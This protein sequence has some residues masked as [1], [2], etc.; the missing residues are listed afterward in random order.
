MRKPRRRVY[1][2]LP[3]KGLR[4]RL[5]RSQQTD[6]SLVHLVNLDLIAT[7]QAD[8]TVMWHLAEDAMLWSRIAEMTGHF[9]AEMQE[10]L[11]VAASVVRRFGVTGKVGFSGLEYQT[12]KAGVEVM[13]AL[14]AMVERH[15][16]VAAA[17]WAELAIDAVAARA[18]SPHRS[19]HDKQQ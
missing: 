4:P 10:Q 15:Q 3:P 13:D 12:A 2:L 8:E 6:L 1:P 7:G 18:N 16:A 19:R 14:A 17:D 11:M 9:E 5:D